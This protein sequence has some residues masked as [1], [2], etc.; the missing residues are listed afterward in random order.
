MDSLMNRRNFL[1]P[2]GRSGAILCLIVALAVSLEAGAQEADGATVLLRAV[3]EK[4][5][6]NAQH[7]LGLL[8]VSGEGVPQNKEAGAELIER[9]AIQGSTLAQND[10]GALYHAGQGVMQD[11]RKA[12]L[13]YGL[14]A[15][16]GHGF[17][18]LNMGGLYFNGQGVP[19][20]SAQAAYWFTLAAQSDDA[21]AA[22]QGKIWSDRLLERARLIQ[23][24]LK[25][26][27]RNSVQQAPSA[28][29]EGA[30]AALIFMAVMV[31]FSGGDDGGSYAPPPGQPRFVPVDPCSGWAAMSPACG[32]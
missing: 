6:A 28:F 25:E 13:Y 10:I 12:A 17:A 24:R 5:D 20:D 30:M 9:A 18:A 31:A 23:A 29:E 21:K 14:A 7:E 3:A 11:F 15:Q 26:Q 8:Y 32:G 16:K 2:M 19:Q 22:S 1:R 27:E 4:G